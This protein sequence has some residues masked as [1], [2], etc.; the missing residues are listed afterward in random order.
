MAKRT[1]LV[2]GGTGALG[3]SVTKRFLADG[4][5]VA[6]S[7]IVESQA[8][9]LRAE[10]SDPDDLFLVEMDATSSADVARAIGKVTDRFGGVD[11]LAHLIGMWKGGTPLGEVDDRTWDLVMDV[12]LRSAFNMARAVLPGMQERDWGR[13]I[14]VSS[15][16]AHQDRSGQIPYA[17]SKAAVATLAESIA[18][19]TRGTNVTANTVAPSVIDT[20]A[21]RKSFPNADHS[22]W[23]G[24]DEIA[25]SISFLATEEAGKL[26]GAWFPVYGSA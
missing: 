16:T 17:I 5:N 13:L 23:V 12:N 7:W 9:E 25:A 6:V 19:E 14:F 1:V 3:T 22:A 15:R 18:E 10:L 2:T 20:E 21:N 8:D 11:V 26:R 4:F 24:P